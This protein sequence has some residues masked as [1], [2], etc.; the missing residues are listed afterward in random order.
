M[1]DM[2][3]VS[4]EEVQSKLRLLRRPLRSPPTEAAAQPVR[5][6]R[7]AGVG[8]SACVGSVGGSP[9]G[10]GCEGAYQPFSLQQGASAQ[11][12]AA[13][14][15]QLQ[16]PSQEAAR[17]SSAPQANRDRRLLR[18]A[19]LQGANDSP[20]RTAGVLAIDGSPKRHR[21]P[22]PAPAA[23]A[24]AYYPFA[25]GSPRLTSPCALAPGAPAA[26]L[27]GS[28]LGPPVQHEV[29]PMS[30]LSPTSPASLHSQGHSRSYPSSPSSAASTPAGASAASSRVRQGGMLSP[31]GSCAEAAAGSAGWSG[32][33]PD[34]ASA[35][36][37]EEGARYLR[38]D[39]LPAFERPVDDRVVADVLQR[40]GAGDDWAAQFGA[41]DDA[42][43]LA[44]FAPRQVT[45]GGHL[46]KLVALIVA[47]VESLRSALARNALRCTGELFATFGK[48]MDR[49]TEVCL[50]PLLRR[51]ADTNAFLAGEADAA[52]REVCREA[53]EARLLPP[54]LAA[55][56]SS[57]RAELRVRAVWCMAMVAQRGVHARS[58]QALKDLRSL[59]DVCVKA[60]G[61]ASADVR[62]VARLLAQVLAPVLSPGAVLE[63]CPVAAKLLA[64]LP[65]G[66]NSQASDA[67]AFDYELARSSTPSCSQ[68]RS[69]PRPRPAPGGASASAPPSGACD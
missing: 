28:D 3:N 30:P 68:S 51:A 52:L 14:D 20:I 23:P 10:C 48:S 16:G 8:A 57:R 13:S 59:A 54:I 69:A 34:A 26:Q 58:Q 15:P 43:R 7:G 38:R 62:R 17:S 11:S 66:Y 36:R 50:P 42:R 18:P 33:A 46:H 63:D 37:R 49:E 6:S 47:L 5:C 31:A 61:D 44:R 24:D 9:T 21:L 22:A 41:I 4:M 67:D 53:S 32:A 40:L 1:A 35:T 64:A 55:W 45:T 12:H 29:C 25:H 56:T 65:A 39:E 19:R 27:A 60:L 2:M